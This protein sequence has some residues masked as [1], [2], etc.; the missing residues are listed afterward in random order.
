M[1]IYAVGGAIRDELLGMPVQD[2][3]YVVVGATPEQLVAQ[4]YR[5]VGK[6]FPVFL[7]PRTHE[8]YALAR[9]ERKTAAGYHGF[10]FH[11]APDVTLEEDLGRRD[12]TVNA[13]AREVSPDGSLIGPVVDPFDGRADLAAKRFRHVGAAFVEDP[14]RIL[15]IARFAARFADFTVADE[16]LALMRAMVAAGEVDALVPERVW[17]EVS[18]GLMEAKPSR[19]FAVL[20]DCG[21]LERI[22]PEVAAL[23]GVPQRADYHPEVDTGVHVMMV[24]DYAAK[25]GYSLP[26]RFAALT[27]D[28]GKATTPEHVLPRHIGHEGRSVDLL[29]PVCDRLRVPNECRDLALLVAR[30]HGNLHQVMGMGA[31]ALVRLLERADALRKPARFA[32][33]LQACESDARGRLGLETQPYPQAE[34]LRRALVAA[35]A[36]D[37]GQV[38]AGMKGNPEGIKDAVHRAR[39]DAV[40]GDLAIGEEA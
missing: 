14:V 12:L 15:R 3:D 2:R 33:M 13:M 31:A 10:Q 7:H 22:L 34:R 37:A 9:T 11:F 38:A 18:R 19:M 6:D 27:H 16:T 35:R 20:R 36:V 25:H 17:Q 4:G 26:V 8:E 40:A 29:K 21:A 5:P 39:V 1:K 30:E 23:F 24:V 32:E 28:L